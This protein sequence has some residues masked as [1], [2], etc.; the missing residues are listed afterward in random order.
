M[1][2][3]AHA[4]IRANAQLVSYQILFGFVIAACFFPVLHA[5]MGC[6]SAT[7]PLRQSE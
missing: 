4:G 2:D 3:I 1:I 5:K 6:A 7:V